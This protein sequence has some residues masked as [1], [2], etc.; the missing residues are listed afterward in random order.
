MSTVFKEKLFAFA[1]SDSFSVM[2]GPPF[3]LIF[4]N[5]SFAGNAFGGSAFNP[6]PAIAIADRGSNVVV[7]PVIY[8]HFCAI[9]NLM[10]SYSTVEVVSRFLRCLGL[11]NFDTKHA[12]SCWRATPTDGQFKQ[13]CFERDRFIPKLIYK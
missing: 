5:H 9:Y 11:T 8:F 12:S 7:I 3:Q 2:V 1:Y 10:L 13:S 6:N 4:L